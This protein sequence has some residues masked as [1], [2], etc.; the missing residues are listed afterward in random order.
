MLDEAGAAFAT[1]L[2]AVGPDRLAEPSTCDGW[3]VRELIAHVVS[4]NLMFAAMVSGTA[5]RP[6]DDVLGDDPAGAFRASLKD[7]KEAFSDE[8]VMDRVF[9]TP[10]GERPAPRLVTTRVIEMGVHGWDLARSTGQR[11]EL[12][13]PVVDAALAQ[14]RMMLSGDRSGLPFGSE[15]Q[16]GP[17]ASPADRLAAYAGRQVT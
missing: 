2:E 11:I 8:G 9:Q 15:R 1:V 14:L 12:P 3:T 16:P 7:L 4:G 5:P 10:M 6:A 17:D 13:E